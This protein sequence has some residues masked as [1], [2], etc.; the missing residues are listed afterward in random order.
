MAALDE[1][2]RV[3]VER[4]G[5]RPPGH[6][7]E[8]VV[9]EDLD[10]EVRH[11]AGLG[12]G[13]VRRVADGED[14]AV[15]LGAQRPLV[16]RHVVQLVTET[17]AGDE[18]RA[19]VE[20][21]GHQQVERHGALVVRHQ[22]PV[23]RVDALDDEV[24]LDV[25]ASLVE[26]RLQVVR[27]DRLGEGARQRGDVGDRDAVTHA[28][29]TQERVGQERELQRCD[30]A[31][32]GHLGDVHHQ[33]A[34]VEPLQHRGQRG[35]AVQGVEVEDAPAPLVAQHAGGLVGPRRGA[36][37]DD[38]VVVRQ[39]APVHERHHVVVRPDDVDLADDEV[40]APS[41]EPAARLGELLGPVPA[42]GQEE[43]PGL[44]GVDVV[45][46]D[47]RD[48]P[49]CAVEAVPQL[50]GHH[51]PGRPGPQHHESLHDGL[52]T[53]SGGCGRRRPGTRRAAGR[54]G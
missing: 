33:P 12:G 50:V 49:L 11:R 23:D 25:D 54:A 22:R 15:R 2:V 14:V 41:D 30:R 17:R 24:G 35:G 44:V 46:V 5:H 31:L 42:E 40:D 52:P 8:E 45:A 29:L 47:H 10:R 1:A 28:P 16:D 32:D 26:H 3:P 51:R 4:L 37:R 7:V 36:A 53:R 34:V 27:R 9:D 48:R 6:L 13:D 21:H 20:R 38:Q 39:R 18:L 19:H 43:V